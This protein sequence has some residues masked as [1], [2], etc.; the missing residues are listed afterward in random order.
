RSNQCRRLWPRP[1]MKSLPV[2]ILL[3]VWRIFPLMQSSNVSPLIE[4]E[5]LQDRCVLTRI[6]SL[7]AQ[8]FRFRF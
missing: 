1:L 4:V 8:N 3:T 2:E 7:V 6:E 5:V